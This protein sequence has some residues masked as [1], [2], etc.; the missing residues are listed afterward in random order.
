MATQSRGLA[1]V[2]GASSG[3]GLSPTKCCAH[4]TLQGVDKLIDAV[5]ERPA[6]LRAEQHRAMAAP[7][8]AKEHV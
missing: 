2:T 5:H 3:I 6:T 4:A 8:S 1:V 7:G